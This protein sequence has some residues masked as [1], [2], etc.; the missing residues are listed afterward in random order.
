MAGILDTIDF[1]SYDDGDLHGQDSWATAYGANADFQVQTSVVY[2]GAKAVSSVQKN[3]S[4]VVKTGTARTTGNQGVYMRSTVTNDE[5]FFHLR[6]PG[7]NDNSAIKLASDGKIKARGAAWFD[8]KASYSANTWYWTEIEWKAGTT[9]SVRFRVDDETWSDWKN[10]A[11][12]SSTCNKVLCPYR[13]GTNGTSYW[14]YLSDS[15][16]VAPVATRRRAA[17]MKFF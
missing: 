1:N 9:G 11:R 8:L 6:E 14:D 5:I 3:G 15:P 12:D 17:F 4:G 16:Y 10:T 7:N 13:T 2:E